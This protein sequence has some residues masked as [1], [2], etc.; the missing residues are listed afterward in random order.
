MRSEHNHPVEESSYQSFLNTAVKVRKF[1]K[2]AA[3]RPGD[4]AAHIVSLKRLT[5]TATAPDKVIT[6]VEA[7][8]VSPDENPVNRS[9]C[10][11]SL[12]NEEIEKD[13]TK[14]GIEDDKSQ[15]TQ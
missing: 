1:T 10:N 13:S 9:S 5:Q 3:R 11:N 8:T 14:N 6:V 2:K 7:K 4:T 15:E 12:I